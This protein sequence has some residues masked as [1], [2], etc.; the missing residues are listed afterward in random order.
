M[1][2]KFLFLLIAMVGMTLQSRAQS[3]SEQ[4][5]RIGMVGFWKMMEMYGRADGEKFHNELDGSN[6]YIFKSNGTC[7]YSTKDR[8]IANAKWTLKDK[9]LHMWGKDTANDPNGIDYSFKLV[10]V[11][12]EKLVLKL[13]DD[14][15]Y[16]YTEFRKSNATLKSVGNSTK[17]RTQTRRK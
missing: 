6:F 10:M 11:T 5:D 15:E 4:A 17:K 3:V 7:Q 13:G 12:P 16:I 8:K 9:V 2:K 1:T 14:E